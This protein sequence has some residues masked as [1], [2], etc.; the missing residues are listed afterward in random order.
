MLIL[1]GDVAFDLC[2]LMDPSL[3]L[4][5]SEVA[6]R[7]LRLEFQRESDRYHSTLW[8]LAPGVTTPLLR[9]VEQ[10]DDANWPP[11]P[12]IQEM[13]KHDGRDGP[14]LA[15]L[16]MAGKSHWSVT[17]IV[18]GDTLELDVACRVKVEPLFLGSTYAIQ[19]ATLATS[20]PWGC[21]IASDRGDVACDL[22]DRGGGQMKA[23][24][25]EFAVMPDLLQADPC[26]RT[27]RWQYRFSIP[28]SP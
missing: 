5:T 13:L 21:V 28:K 11:S 27:I 18:A 6:G 9:S 19:G 26:P 16:G 14:C 25:G 8:L 7:A 10:G 12:V 4:Q 24:S 17:V 22:S 1:I 20:Q 23:S 3:Q 2:R 15:G